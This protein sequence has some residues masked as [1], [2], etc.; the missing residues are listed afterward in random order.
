MKELQ[1]RDVEIQQLKA[2]SRDVAQVQIQLHEEILLKEDYAHQLSEA[3]VSWLEE[4]PSFEAELE[5]KEASL[6]QSG[7]CIS[8]LETLLW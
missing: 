2:T 1:E 3:Q 6:R 4:K 8:E 5:V 7:E